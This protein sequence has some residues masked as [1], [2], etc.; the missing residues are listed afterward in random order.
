MSDITRY[1]YQDRLLKVTLI[2]SIVALLMSA[3]M[4]VFA[5]YLMFGG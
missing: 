4:F 2:F 5:A 3:G 1:K